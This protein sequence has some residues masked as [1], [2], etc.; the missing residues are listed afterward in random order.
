MLTGQTR[1][2]TEVLRVPA[3]HKSGRSSQSP[4]RLRCE[5]WVRH[6]RAIV[7]R[8]GGVLLSLFAAPM[9]PQDGRL[10]LI[11]VMVGAL[12]RKKRGTAHQNDKANGN[13]TH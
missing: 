1:Y 4:L 8:T 9:R 13:P 12:G 5:G 3:V 7:A 6:G 2:G 11:G 10:A